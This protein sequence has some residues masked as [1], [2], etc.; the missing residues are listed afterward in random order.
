MADAVSRRQLKEIRTKSGNNICFECSKINPQ[1]VSVTYGIWICIDCSGKHRM[2][3]LHLSQVKSITMDKWTERDIDKVRVGG[4]NQFS[5]FLE[6]HD[7]YNQDWTLEEKYNSLV[8][9]KD[10]L[11]G[12]LS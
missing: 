11:S 12:H 5:Q 2:I 4:N 10:L 6:N 8:N 1:W 3:G 7:Q 9:K